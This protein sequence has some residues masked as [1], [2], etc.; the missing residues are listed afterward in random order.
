MDSGRHRS[1]L[2]PQTKFL[3]HM[4]RRIFIL[5][6]VHGFASLN[7]T[8]TKIQEGPGTSNPVTVLLCIVTERKLRW[9]IGSSSNTIKMYRS[10]WMVIRKGH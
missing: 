2:V 8:H 3:N 6:I 7:N 5:N 9:V 4:G 10:V 1:V